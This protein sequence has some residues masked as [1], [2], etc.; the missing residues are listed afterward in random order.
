MTIIS[1][2]K[3]NTNSNMSQRMYCLIII[4]FLFMTVLPGKVLKPSHQNLP[5]QLK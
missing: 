3:I 2:P 1:P 4:G 5:A